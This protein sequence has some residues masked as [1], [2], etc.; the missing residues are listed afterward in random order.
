MPYVG[1]TWWE[2]ELADG[3]QTE[4]HAECLTLSRSNEGAFQLSAAAKKVGAVLPREI[5][6]QLRQSALNGALAC[7]FSAGVFSGLSVS[8]RELGVHWQRLWLAH[9]NL[10]VFATYNGSPEAWCNEQQDVYAMLATLR[11]RAA[12][13]T[14]PA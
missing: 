14:L 12:E 9:G 5:E 8:Y 11:P 2:L 4:D 3:W 1:G 13:N 7:P 6:E 10:L